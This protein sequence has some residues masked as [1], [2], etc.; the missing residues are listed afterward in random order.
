[1]SHNSEYK[2]NKKQNKKQQQI[3]I[4]HIHLTMVYIQTTV[5]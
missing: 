4:W 2:Q 1:M 5:S 3:S